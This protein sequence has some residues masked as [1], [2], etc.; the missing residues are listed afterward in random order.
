MKPDPKPPTVFPSIPEMVAAMHEH[1]ATISDF[2]GW[3]PYDA[4]QEL[5]VGFWHRHDA[6]VVSLQS[7]VRSEVGDLF[8]TR[9]G[10]KTLATILSY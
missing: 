4:P 1:R 2:D 10:R 3:K 8:R 9:E 5:V 7:L 6:F